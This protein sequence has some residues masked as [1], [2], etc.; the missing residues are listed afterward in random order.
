MYVVQFP[1]EKLPSS[2]FDYEAAMNEAMRD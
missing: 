2:A 1:N